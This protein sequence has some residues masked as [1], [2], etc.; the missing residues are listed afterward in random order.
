MSD[1]TRVNLFQVVA[2]ITSTLEARRRADEGRL[3]FGG[4]PTP[5]CGSGTVRLRRFTTNVPLVWDLSPSRV[6]RSNGQIEGEMESH[7]QRP[8]TDADVTPMSGTPMEV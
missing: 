4:R 2:I 5:P 7:A 3:S 6:R 1:R 8:V